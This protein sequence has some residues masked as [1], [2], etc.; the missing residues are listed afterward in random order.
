MVIVLGHIRDLDP[1]FIGTDRQRVALARQ[2][3]VLF[4]IEGLMVVGSLGRHA[5]KIALDTPS[6]VPSLALRKGRAFGR[7]LRDI[8]V[9]A[10]GGLTQEQAA[11]VMRSGPHPVDTKLHAALMH[12]TR[13]NRHRYYNPLWESLP[14][15]PE[16]LTATVVRQVGS[17]AYVRTPTAWAQGELLVCGPG[18]RRIVGAVRDYN[19]FAARVKQ[20]AGPGEFPVNAIS[21]ASR[22]RWGSDY[23]HAA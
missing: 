15:L 22:I 1:S 21:V 6:F 16:E 17:Q 13:F 23:S 10:P 12:Q 3:D 5:T 19:A 4:S 14:D 2:L 11:L 18:G 8:D 20:A 9:I 7:A